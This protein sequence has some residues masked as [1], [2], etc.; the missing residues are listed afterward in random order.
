MDKGK[1]TKALNKAVALEHTASLQY[2]QHALL[3]R[4]PWRK[5]FADFFNQ[6]SHNALEHAHNFGRKVVA[7]GGVPTVEVGLTVRQSLDLTEMLKQDL[8]L[9]RHALKAYLEAHSLSDDDVALRSMLETHI[10]AEQRGIDELEM[11]LELV[12]TGAVAP[13]VKL[14]VAK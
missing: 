3:V 10:D 9:E 11:Y 4:G 2:Q 12:K 6:E 1:M 7:L 13:E 5:A 8:E 14:Q